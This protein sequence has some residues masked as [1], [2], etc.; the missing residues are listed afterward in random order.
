MA[1]NKTRQELIDL[2]RQMPVA[3]RTHGRDSVEVKAIE[4]RIAELTVI[5]YLNK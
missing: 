5:I 2:Q 1:T 3:I 4:N